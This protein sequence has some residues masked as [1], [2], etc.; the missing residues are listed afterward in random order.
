MT[1]PEKPTFQG[2]NDDQRGLIRLPES[3][4]SDLLPHIDDFNQLR[5]LLY[6]FWHLEQQ[7]TKVRYFRWMDLI[8]DTLLC[9]M[10]QGQE[11]LKNALDGLIAMGVV[12]KADLPWMDETYYFINGPQGRAAVS[13]IE[14]GEWGSIAQERKPIQLTSQKPNIFQLYEENIGPITPLIADILKDDEKTYPTAWISDAIEI[15]VTRNIRNWKYIR[16]ILN[17]WQTEGRGNDQYR[18]DNSQDPE[19]YRK[20][21]LNN[22]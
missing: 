14:S 3:F 2:F 6:M 1:P 4:F 22:E 18:R 11:A 8:S 12:L 17:R 9:E 19:S 20:S 15:A 10:T 13:A 21:W 16:A 7:E 5:L